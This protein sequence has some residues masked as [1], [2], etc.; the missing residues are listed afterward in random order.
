MIKR[1]ISRPVIGGK[2][3]YVLSGS[4][5]DPRKFEVLAPVWTE[6]IA[7]DGLFDFD[8]NALEENTATELVGFV[9]IHLDFIMFHDRLLANIR[10]AILVLLVL[11][12]GFALYARRVLQNALRSISQLEEPIRELAKGNLGV[13]FEPA[14]H[15]EIS[16]I[17]DA[18]ETTATALSERDAELL[19][20]ANHDNLTGLYNRRRFGEELRSNLF[21]IMRHGGSSALFFIDLDQFKYVNDLCGHP[22]GDR[23][24]R[25][26]ADE[27]SRSVAGNAI[28]ARFGGDE[29][30][31]LFP[32]ADEK[33]A[34]EAAS[35][36]M[37]NMRRM[38]HIENDH[39][40]HIHCSIGVTIATPANMH[41]DELIAQA[42]KACREAKSAG[43]NRVRFFD[44]TESGDGVDLEVGWINRL[45]SALDEDSFELRFQPINDIRSGKTTH[46]EV[47][48]RARA[49]DGSLVSP[50]AFLPA[51]VRFGMMSEIDLWVIRNAA[52]AYA[53]HVHAHPQLKFS[54]NISANAFESEDLPRYVHDTFDEFNVPPENIV[55]EITESLAIRR[56]MHV[57]RQI[58]ALRALGCKLAL[59]DFGT[60][61]SSFSYLQQLDCD[62]IKIDGAFVNELLENPVDQKVIR[63]IADIGR[64]AGMRTIA[65][66]VQSAEA[67]ALL[68]ELGVDLAQGYFVGKPK[69][70][71]QFSATP[72]SLESRR[73]R[74]RKGRPA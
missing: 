55:L 15:R 48:I 66:Y 56:P 69:K 1:Y 7:D 21:D 35:R 40:F 36:I 64:E 8:P 34:H 41:Q 11:L 72:I 37:T 24:I 10:A 68:E 70:V 23:L 50:D 63:L 53:E 33:E 12:I 45:R 62:Y 60:G 26:V 19:E 47:L 6:A 28:I 59:D 46:H 9:A 16:D 43:R 29:F 3:P 74:R 22:A 58:A 65:E 44:A 4:L 51:A 31:A 18:L 2:E 42:D 25:K 14:E 38:A 67:L 49:D 57:E 32:D 20:L 73:G 39:V 17:V 61:Y 13:K 5:V 71:P 52:K 30:A 54:I 27:L